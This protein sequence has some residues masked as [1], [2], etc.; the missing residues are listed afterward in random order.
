MGKKFIQASDIISESVSSTG[1]CPDHL[2]S[3]KEENLHPEAAIGANLQRK[4]Q[5]YGG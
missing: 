4:T 3:A 2:A 5:V 1:V